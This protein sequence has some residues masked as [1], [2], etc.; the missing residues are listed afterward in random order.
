MARADEL[1]QALEFCC[2]TVPARV[3]TESGKSERVGTTDVSRI[4]QHPQER[5]IAWLCDVLVRRAAEPFLTCRAWA[6]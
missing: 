2:S 3:W 1:M 6:P 4:A 5:L